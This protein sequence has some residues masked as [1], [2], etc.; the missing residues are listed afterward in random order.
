MKEKKKLT[1]G[2]RDVNNVS[3]A[4]FFCPLIISQSLLCPSFPPCCEQRLAAL[5]WGVLTWASVGPSLQN[6]YNLE[7]NRLVKINAKKSQ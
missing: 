2:P 7:Y 6:G 3:W 5:T 4:F 1:H